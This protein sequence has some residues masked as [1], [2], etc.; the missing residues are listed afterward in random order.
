MGGD[1]L[2]LPVVTSLAAKYAVTPGQ[3][4]VAWCVALG[5]STTPKS[6]DP[7]RQAQN[8]AAADLVLEDADVAALSALD[9]TEPDVTSPHTF[10][11]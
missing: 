1:L 8:L 2:E 10:G 7:V 5:L 11:H 3:L 4:L 9:G 6:G